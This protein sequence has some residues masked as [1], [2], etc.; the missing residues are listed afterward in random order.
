MVAE[1]S[2]PWR[3][4]DLGPICRNGHRRTYKNLYRHG[5]GHRRCREC[6]RET[7]ARYRLAH[8]DRV[9]YKPRP[10][11]ARAVRVFCTN[12]HP[13]TPETTRRCG[14]QRRCRECLARTQRAYDARQKA[15]RNQGTTPGPQAPYSASQ[16]PLAGFDAV[17]AA[18]ATQAREILAR[19]RPTFR[20]VLKAGERA[21][22]A[23]RLAATGRMAGPVTPERIIAATAEACGVTVADLAGPSR[24][25][26][27]AHPR[28]AAY[29]LIR[30]LC[31]DATFEAI[32]RALGGRD[33][34][35][36]SWG[37][38]KIS[39]LVA[40]GDE[41]TLGDLA[42]IRAALEGSP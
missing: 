1:R 28:Q 39:R 25:Y 26:E 11:R 36:V 8:P 31:P 12:G 9:A 19:G 15:K 3:W 32:G 29:Y 34:T 7:Q 10:H 21:E 40:A 24:E 18:Q 30:Q 17:A 4:P 35:S 38:T 37:Y 5:N 2:A 42:A 22:R 14:E 41:D 20:D 23:R 13:L 6:L 27:I 16:A 33:H